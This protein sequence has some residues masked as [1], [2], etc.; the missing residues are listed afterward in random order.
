M[1]MRKKNRDTLNY[2]KIIFNESEY[3]LQKQI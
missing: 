1:E 2:L 3:F